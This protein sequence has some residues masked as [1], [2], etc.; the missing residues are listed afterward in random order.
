MYE[1]R[2]SCLRVVDGD[3]VDLRVDM[4]FHMAATLRFRLLGVDAP[5]LFRG[6]G[7]KAQAHAAKLFV[8]QVLMKDTMASGPWPLRIQTQKADSFGRWLATIW[9]QHPGG[10]ERELGA[11]LMEEGLAVPY[12]G[13]S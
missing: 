7:D 12:E 8:E 2:A 3:T 13:K 10:P 1:Y 9:I 5:E 11:M 6:K 4:G